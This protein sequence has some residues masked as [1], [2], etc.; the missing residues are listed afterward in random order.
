MKYK[1]FLILLI[2]TITSCAQNLNT[3]NVKTPFNS[4]GFAYIYN[5]EDFNKKIINKKFDNNLL[6]VAHNKLRVGT[7]IKLI[8]PKTNDF[9]V[10]K[11]SKKLNYP[12]FYK[13]LITTPVALKL[14]LQ[15]DL[16]LIEIIEIKKNKSFVA[17]KAKIHVEEKKLHS[18]APVET[19]KISNISRNKKKINNVNKDKFFIN[20]GV[21]YSKN[22]AFFLKD[23][24]TKEL[25]SFD[26]NKLK[27]KIKKTNKVTLL[28]GPYTTINSM[29]ND[30]ILLK[31][32]GF[33]ELDISI[34]E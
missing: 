17:K 2:F 22:S 6:Q 12:D 21:F 24:I 32:F 30:Y 31:N 28:S 33:E 29:K 16:P 23:R 5:E 9:I 8:N 4:K 10:L 13:I 18:N 25:S 27:I 3:P 7:L 15:K 34:N 19:V 11:N 14:N 1:L 20:I 26:S